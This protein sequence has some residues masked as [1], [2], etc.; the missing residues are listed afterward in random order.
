MFETGRYIESMEVHCR[1]RERENDQKN[2]DMFLVLCFFFK[3]SSPTPPFLPG[4]VVVTVMWS[5]SSLSQ[6]LLTALPA[7]EKMQFPWQQPHFHWHGLILLIVNVEKA[8]S[9]LWS[10]RE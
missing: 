9:L 6:Q 8:S 2:S 7:A 10:E 3:C 1:H 5:S 4:V